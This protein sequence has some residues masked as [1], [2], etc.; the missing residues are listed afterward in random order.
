MA[1]LAKHGPAAPPAPG[2][3]AVRRILCPVDFSELSLRAVEQ[4]TGLARANGA[5]IIAFFVFPA[6]AGIERGRAWTAAGRPDEA[7]RA[8]VVKDL[9]PFLAPARQA[10]VPVRVVLA[11]GE[12]AHEIVA[13]AETS[14]AD[15]IVMG[16]HGRS[17]FERW[18]LGSTAESVLRN[19]TCS[20]LTVAGD[21][22][23]PDTSSPG[24]GPVVCALELHD[25]STATLQTA[26]SVAAMTGRMVKLV[27]V[28]PDLSHYK[29]AALCAGIAWE[30]LRQDLE[31]DARQRLAAAAAS[32]GGRV[33]DTIVASGKPYREILRI[34]GEC[35]AALIVMGI[36]GRAPLHRSFFGSSAEHV[37]REAACP[38]LAVRRA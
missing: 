7:V 17:G 5:E 12:A 9:E 28:L 18:A 26:L 2:A 14:A 3:V 34:A 36:H 35:D 20:V 24:G 29:A 30:G 15:L 13:A 21:R 11:S 1:T 10:G 8:T 27:H 19:A 33:A 16:T 32:D 22:G 38:V 25:S 37:V 23:E 4:A 6:Q 31:K